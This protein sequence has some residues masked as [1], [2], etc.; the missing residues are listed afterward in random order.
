[1]LNSI[2]DAI[3]DLRA[4][5]CVIVVD[6]ENRE[7]EGDL[8]ALADRITPSVV[9]F[10]VT[11]GKG[12]LCVPL[13]QERAE[14]LGLEQMA[15]KN[16]DSHGTAFTVSV[17]STKCTTGI[18]ASDRATTIQS[19]ASPSKNLK[20]FRRPGHIFPLTARPRGVFERAGHTEAT[21]DIARLC[22]A[23][24]A[25]AICEILKDDGTM[26]R[27]PDLE[28]FTR[29]HNLKIISIEDL[30]EYRIHHE[31]VIQEAVTARLPTSYGTF[32]VLAYTTN[33]DNYIYITLVKGI[34]DPATPTLVRVH[35]EC[36]TGDIFHSTRCDCGRQLD[37]ALAAI[38]NAEAGVLVYM[39][40]EGRGI[41]LLDKLRSYALQDQGADTVEANTLLGY[42]PDPRTYHVANQIL[43]DLGVRKVRLLTNNPRKVSALESSH[44]DVVERVPLEVPPTRENAQYLRTKKIKLGHILSTID[45]CENEEKTGVTHHT[46]I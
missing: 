45:V 26:A 1:M 37:L 39:R 24:P 25:G 41:G 18:S 15:K 6:D 22:G 2:E 8:L 21:V 36:L 7:N 32:K 43:R 34:I 16:T 35:S 38:Q 19:L 46:E 17:D 33:I 20:D 9:N 4:G 12:L 10:M 31:K 42:P 13:T 14:E 29:E 23:F 3:S 5:R 30:I 28:I 11:H 40:Q 44:F 27:L